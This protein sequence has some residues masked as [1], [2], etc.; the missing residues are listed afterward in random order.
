MRS[1]G[2]PSPL[3]GRRL[4]E[5]SPYQEHRL[6]KYIH[7][8]FV[9]DWLNVMVETDMSVS[10]VPPPGFERPGTDPLVHSL[11]QSRSQSEADQNAA[12]AHVGDAQ[13]VFVEGMES[14]HSTF[15]RNQFLVS[16]I[17]K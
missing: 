8:F 1:I 13:S 16:Q 15:D 9:T 11:I 14:Y 4:V 12:H 10:S 2:I 3:R 5:R 6:P 7:H 17:L